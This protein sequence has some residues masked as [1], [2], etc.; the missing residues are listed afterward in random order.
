MIDIHI[1]EEKK[2]ITVKGKLSQIMVETGA[3]IS[4]IYE[5]IC[6]QDKIA[7]E[8]FK[9]I[10]IEDDFVK[11]VFQTL[12]E[13]KKDEEMECDLKEDIKRDLYRAYLQEFTEGE[14]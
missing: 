11:M 2:E 9:V 8:I 6:R 5:A 4:L 1:G 3:I 12:S 10:L 7:G 14:E 13:A